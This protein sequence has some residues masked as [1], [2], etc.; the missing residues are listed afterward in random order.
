MVNHELK[1]LSQC[2]WSNKTLNESKSE[3]I[4]FRSQRKNLPQESEIKINNYKLK[5]NG[6]V[7]YPETLIDEVLTCN[8]QIASTSMKLARANDI[9]SKLR[10][11]VPNDICISVY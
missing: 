11:F 9:L 8:K 3:L 1:F 10:Y 4:I 5:L 2:L 6:H 7:K